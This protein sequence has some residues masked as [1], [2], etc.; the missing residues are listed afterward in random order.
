MKKSMKK[1][2]PLAVVSSLALGSVIGMNQDNTEAKAKE[3]KNGKAKNVIFMIGDGMGV[4]YTTALRYM[5]DNP[6]TMEMEKTAFD[7]YLVGLQTTYPEDE[8]EN[9]TDSAAAATA[10]SGGVKTYNNAIAVDND[11]SDVKTV[12]E[13]AKE[14]NMSTGIVSTSEITHATP[15]SYGAHEESRKSED[16]IANDYYDE[17]INGKHKIDVMLGGGTDFF[18]RDDRN[19]AEQF[20][21]D[22]YSYVKSADELKKDKNDQILGLFAESGM[23]KMID[24]DEKQPSLADMTTAALDRLKGDKDGFFLMVEGSQ[25]DWAGHDNDVVGAMSEMRDFEQAFEKVRDFAKEN[26]ETLVIVTADHSTGGISIGSDGEYNWDPAPIQAAKHTPDYMA[27]Q[28]VN[29]ASVEETLADNIDLELTEEEIDS[30]KTAAEKGDQTEIDNAI[31]KIFDKR[32]GT[33]WTTDGHTGDDVPVY[34]YGPQKEKFA[35]LIDNT[36]QANMIFELLK[37][38]GKIKDKK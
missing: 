35:G 11:K 26:G 13:Q 23:D 22:G 2:L 5:N 19:I 6:D 16:A 37:N 31:E 1:I 7:P 34:A 29:G 14:N 17:M 21:K 27:E 36:D 30:V 20:K 10:M 33:G 4:P 8:K 15:A 32:S 18:E 24:R 9:V 12:L 38:K 28:I 3:S 25:I